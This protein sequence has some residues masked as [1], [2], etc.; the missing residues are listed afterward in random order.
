MYNGTEFTSALAVKSSRSIGSIPKVA[1]ELDKNRTSY[2]GVGVC[3]FFAS[4]KKRPGPNNQ[5]AVHLG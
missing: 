2:P 4:P 3:S 5:G 1:C